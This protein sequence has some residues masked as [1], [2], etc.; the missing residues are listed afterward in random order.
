MRVPSRCFLRKTFRRV[1]SRAK[2]RGDFFE[3]NIAV[4]N[5]AEMF[6]TIFNAG[7]LRQSVL[8]RFSVFFQ[9]LAGAHRTIAQIFRP[10]TPCTFANGL[11]FRLSVRFSCLNRLFHILK[12]GFRKTDGEIRIGTMLKR[13]RFSGNA[14]L[15][16]YPCFHQLQSARQK[17]KGGQTLFFS[18]KFPDNALMRKTSA[19]RKVTAENAVIAL[20][21]VRRREKR[22]F[23]QSHHFPSSIK[24]FRSI[25]P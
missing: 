7:K 8:V 18:E 4:F 19:S 5:P 17:Y 2:K 10:V 13:K 3:A 15:L 11:Q 22:K 12:H 1:R 6:R 9:V 16:I 20:V 24:P 25:S 21:R 14:A 23:S